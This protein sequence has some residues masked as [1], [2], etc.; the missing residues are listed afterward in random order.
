MVTEQGTP[1]NLLNGFIKISQY[2][3]G[4]PED[5]DIWQEAPK[6]LLNF[7]KAD[8]SFVDARRHQK[9][10]MEPFC[11]SLEQN[12]CQHAVA[13]S[14]QI[15]DEV[16]RNGFLASEMLDLPER[17][18]MAFLPVS[19]AHQVVA[20]LAVGHCQDSHLG[21]EELDIYLGVASLLETIL[22]K[23]I[24]E[25]RFQLMAD[26]VPEMLFRIAMQPDN[27]KTFDYVSKGAFHVLGCS[28]E[29][30]KSTPLL[31]FSKLVKGDSL[32]LDQQIIEAAA[33]RQRFIHTVCWHTPEGQKKYIEFHAQALQEEDGT[34][35]L[36][37][38]AQDITTR[39][40]AEEQIRKA[41]EEWER[42]FDAIGDI[43]TLQDTEMRILR[44]N[45]AACKALKG[46]P[47]EL[48]GKYCYE[49]F[50]AE[51]DPCPGCPALAT[52]QDGKINSAEIT[53][54]YLA[55]TFQ[56]SSSPLVDEA[57]RLAGIVHF[58]KDISKQKKL[59]QQL[60]Q[61]QKMEAIGT[62]AGGIAHDFNNILACILGYADLILD[63]LPEGGKLWL[64]QEQVIK[65]G[66]RA[67]D[68]V[69]Q[70]LAFS[71]QAEQEQIPLAIHIVVKEAI[72]LLRSSIP[73][74]IEIKEN[75][76]PK[77]GMVLADPTQLHQIVMNLCTNAY[78]AMRETGGVLAIT[79]SACQIEDDD[80]K[81]SGA[82]LTPGSYVK[83]AISDTGC[84]MDQKTME[85]IFD[86][87]FTTKKIGEGTGLGLA[88]VHGIVKTYNGHITVHSE[89]GKGT[90]FHVYLPQ[91][92][93]AQEVETL[94]AVK[95]PYPTGTEK[96]LIV[97]DEEV[98]VQ[99]ERLMLES[100]GYKVFAHTNSKELLQTFK[101]APQDFDLVITDM[102]MP[103]MTGADLSR[104]ILAI[105]P[106]MPIILCTGFSALIDKEKAIAAGI[107]EY[108]MKP[109]VKRDLA[110]VVRK[111]LDEN[112]S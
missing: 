97:D 60:L 49:L 41:K 39:K 100:L 84:G 101:S 110:K 107:S 4:L 91:I 23:K 33:K 59:E 18:A 46:T 56:V 11:F 63:E 24:S 21:K 65:A 28:P 8:I 69:K 61:A 48:V 19:H 71:R 77:S 12:H 47:E 88:M 99:M 80:I 57:G 104:Q 95:I 50:A 26:N 7:F 25:Q 96:I 22:A 87:Y 102:T 74:T 70:I 14:R 62:L 81:V 44:V 105:R 75:I 45:Q 58:A 15:T 51:T 10:T 106:D 20:V 82:G 73:T 92:F 109:V 108:I 43:V 40:Q 38:A 6:A 31:F 112:K 29:E 86:P 53:H 79:L 13:G 67:K 68:L 5:A 1:R 17:H 36:D 78:Q 98:L 85:N 94:K 32:S 2:L 66:D 27:A 76:D 64:Q 83:L 54:K 3:I 55:C 30:L 42:T 111:A 52:I 72:K 89:P 35:Y 16:M 34:I 93:P 37:G 103:E 90:T 9:T